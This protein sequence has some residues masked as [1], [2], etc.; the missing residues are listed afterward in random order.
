MKRVK[1][2]DDRPSGVWWGETMI[3]AQGHVP[4]HVHDLQ[5]RE[6]TF[7]GRTVHRS[8]RLCSK[9]YPWSERSSSHKFPAFSMPSGVHHRSCHPS[10]SH[11]ILSNR[12]ESV[13]VR[14]C[15]NQ[16]DDRISCCKKCDRLVDTISLQEVSVSSPRW[17]SARRCGVTREAQEFKS[18]L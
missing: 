18:H 10:R 9:M 8:S 15:Y 16:Q 1:T 13:C 7:T 12:F 11:Q 17:R 4:R 3:A 14:Q 5:R 2:G 6:R